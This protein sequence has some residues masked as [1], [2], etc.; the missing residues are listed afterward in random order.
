MQEACQCLVIPVTVSAHPTSK[1]NM[2]VNIQNGLWGTEQR[3]GSQLYMMQM[4]GSGITVK[5]A[6]PT[7]LYTYFYTYIYKYT[8]M[9]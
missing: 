4:N 8:H 1:R 9:L 3:N 2:D 5:G 6:C 7:Y